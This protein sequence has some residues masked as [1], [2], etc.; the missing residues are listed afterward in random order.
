MLYEK[1][2]FLRKCNMCGDETFN[3]KASGRVSCVKADHEFKGLPGLN[4]DETDELYIATQD[5]SEYYQAIITQETDSNVVMA[6]QA[7]KKKI[8]ELLTKLRQATT[9]AHNT[10]VAVETAP[11]P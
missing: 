1:G 7:R 5:R 10:Q 2:Q 6:L 3:I 11:A 9:R 8:D 4:V